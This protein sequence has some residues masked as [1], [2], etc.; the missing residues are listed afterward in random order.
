MIGVTVPSLALTVAVAS[1]RAPMSG[2]CGGGASE[3]GLSQ[4]TFLAVITPTSWS[5]PPGAELFDRGIRRRRWCAGDADGCNSRGGYRGQRRGAELQ[6]ALLPRRV[7]L[8]GGGS[9]WHPKIIRFAV[10]RAAFAFNYSPSALSL[11]APSVEKS[12]WL[13]LRFYAVGR[14][15]GKML[16]NERRRRSRL[17]LS[18][19]GR[20][21]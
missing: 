16:P 15:R 1:H 20:G 6:D 18:A 9:A 7:P 14:H 2:Y 8:T 21:E 3:L 11:T 10:S 12:T 19:I 5:H 4:S 17:T 13:T